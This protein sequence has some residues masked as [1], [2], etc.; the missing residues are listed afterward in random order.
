[1]LNPDPSRLVEVFA[2]SAAGAAGSFG[3]GYL[4]RSDVVVTAAH[5][6]P[7]DSAFIDVRVLGVFGWRRA[8]LAWRDDVADI[9]LL[10]VSLHGQVDTEPVQF[11]RL[12]TGGSRP[13]RSIAFPASQARREAQASV[14]D[15]EEVV[16]DLERV[17]RTKQGVLTFHV[18]RAV[19]TAPGK[20]A[21]PWS[22][23]SGAPV[24][25]GRYLVGVVREAPPEFN[26][27]R[28]HVAPIQPALGDAEFRALLGGDDGSDAVAF[29]VENLDLES[30]L[31]AQVRQGPSP[32]SL[33]M[34][35]RPEF[36]VVPFRGRIDE[37]T[38]MRSW[39]ED[40]RRADP[41][42]LV[43]TGE[44]GA[45]KT[46]LGYELVRVARE[47]GWTAGL[48]RPD[49]REFDLFR[50]AVGDVFVV[51]DYAETT[52]DRALA[53]IREACRGQA[54]RMRVLLL[55]RSNSDWWSVIVARADAQTRATLSNAL[56]RKL[57]PVE[58]SAVG[59]HAAY[60][61]A[62]EAFGKTLRLPVPAV[63][64]P[65]LDRDL[66]DR[67]LYLHATALLELV[68]GPRLA[69]VP[70]RDDL[71]RA[72]LD[73]E[74]ARYWEPTAGE[75]PLGRDGAVRKRVIATATL[76]IARNEREA[77]AAI[78]AIPD[79][80]EPA[81]EHTRRSL[82]RWERG[83][84]GGHYYLRAL[85]PDVLGEVL[86]ADVLAEVP[87]M[88]ARLV[89]VS[90]DEQLQREI[91]VL[92]RAAQGHRPAALDAL[93]AMLRRD[94]H[95]VLPIGLALTTELGDPLGVAITSAVEEML[96][97]RDPDP[98]ILDLLLGA[99]PMGS[100]ALENV[101]DMA[102]IAK[103]MW[104]ER[105]LPAGVDKDVQ[106]ADLNLDLSVRLLEQGAAREALGCAAEAWTAYD[107]LCDEH[108][109]EP[110]LFEVGL[111]RAFERVANCSLEVGDVEN[112]VIAAEDSVSHWAAIAREDVQYVMQFAAALNNAAHVFGRAGDDRAI[113][114]AQDAVHLRRQLVENGACTPAELAIT[115]LNFTANLMCA[116]RFEEAIDV[117]REC[118]DLYEELSERQPDVY[119]RTYA[120][121]IENLAGSLLQSGNAHEAK[122]LAARAAQIYYEYVEMR[123]ESARPQLA[124]ALHNLASAAVGA[125]DLETALGAEKGAVGVLTDLCHDEKGD[126]YRPLL[127]TAYSR[128]ALLHEENGDEAEAARAVEAALDEA[129]RLPNRAEGEECELLGE[130][131]RL[132]LKAGS[133]RSALESA[134][135]LL[136]LFRGGPGGRQKTDDAIGELTMWVAGF[137]WK[138]GETEKAIELAED[139]VALLK[140]RG[141]ED[142]ELLRAQQFVT[143]MKAVGSPR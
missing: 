137:A 135:E 14:R 42:V 103:R 57:G 123:V 84:Y 17:T 41:S 22:G 122:E 83:L 40:D 79:L 109:S 35:L 91:S 50:S 24:F 119:R 18:A 81:L 130:V 55:A 118:V 90:D 26:G 86:V 23:A 45:G 15:T 115:L 5:V 37:L 66:Y 51:M 47:L 21:S 128:V 43:L 67:I 105:Q 129:R 111:A 25:C 3:T 98:D 89:D 95:R 139:G 10:R 104:A 127:V 94:L 62:L 116:E 76:T 34:L 13:A 110:H 134:E 78:A 44:G 143:A 74:D 114:V 131:A 132:H 71:L 7:A 142:P 58:H 88:A 99:M 65:D 120:G 60:M 9:A 133:L 33:A 136:T 125:D 92:T 8:N 102:L 113:E 32:Q 39:M 28:L 69:R 20:Q 59:R 1:V 38:Y 2:G 80:A 56:L 107:R 54:E 141:S 93:T 75:V 73:R 16:G 27:Y 6:V 87:E 19:A 30:L 121:A 31:W 97:P 108:G 70:T 126:R 46:R 64:P 77:S 63:V 11:G 48:V 96:D 117:A 52:I 4:V 124:N 53:L 29:S 12:T 61:E 36:G 85:E 101:L 140:G 138:A 106:I 82:A 68:P 49:V 72:L 112:A 100:T